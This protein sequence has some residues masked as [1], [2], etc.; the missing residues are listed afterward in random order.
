MLDVWIQESPHLDVFIYWL[1][2]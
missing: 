1:E 2:E